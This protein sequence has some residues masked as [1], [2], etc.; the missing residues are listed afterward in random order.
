MGSNITAVAFDLDGTLYPNH[1]L[2][3]RLIPF[4]FRRCRLLSAFRKARD[5]IRA[6]QEQSPASFRPDFYDYQ[7]Q[8]TAERLNMPPEKMKEK[9]EKQIYRKLEGYF[10][11]IELFSH[12]REMLADLRKAPLKL[13]I[14]SDFPPENKLK[15]LGLGDYWDTMLCSEKTG[16]LKPALQPFSVLAD[17]LGSPPEQILYVGN[18]YH[19]DAIGAKRAGMKTALITGRFAKKTAKPGVDF[20]FH[21]YRQ[22][23]NYVLQ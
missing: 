13:G 18:S 21:D 15:H 16:A 17:A 12:V 1:R 4:L 8:L 5:Q 19:Y 2:Y 7:T 3:I 23:R 6:E 9:I 20:T 22:L 10:P 11:E 14:L